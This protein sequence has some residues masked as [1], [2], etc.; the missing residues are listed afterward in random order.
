MKHVTIV[1]VNWNGKKDT[2]ECLT[3]LSKLSAVI[4]QLSA[5]PAPGLLQGEILHEGL[6]DKL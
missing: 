5:I 6:L 2:I 4:C 3:S 1:I